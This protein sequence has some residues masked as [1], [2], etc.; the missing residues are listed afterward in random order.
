VF[1]FTL[2]VNELIEAVA[3]AKLLVRLVMLPVAELTV[4]VKLAKFALVVLT[5]PTIVEIV[6]ELTPPTWFT[7]AT[8]VTFAV[9]SKPPLV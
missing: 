3:E 9:P 6:D 5:V 8:P 4:V 1:E 2:S 7:V